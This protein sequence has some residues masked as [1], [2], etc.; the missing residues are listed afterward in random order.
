VKLFYDASHAFGCSHQGQMIGTFGDAEVFS[1]HA[2][3]FVNSAEGGA[4]MTN[5]TELAQRLRQ[6]RNFG[7]AGPD[8]V[9]Q[10][11]TNGKMTE[12]SAAMGLTSLEQMDQLI[13]TNI[14]NH[15]LYQ[16]SLANISGVELMMFSPNERANYQHIVIEIDQKL[17]GISRDHLAQIL[18]AENV[19]ARRY[20]HPGCHKMEP[21]RSNAECQNNQLPVTERIAESVLSLPTGTGVDA[22]KIRQIAD[23][24]RFVVE[25]G[26]AISHR[27]RSGPALDEADDAT[28][29]WRQSA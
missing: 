4:V 11:G 26:A 21:Y 27:V 12:F 18:R 24:I 2:T 10:L 3:K 15:R 23:I 1:F 20:F 25:H 28:S 22:A 19:L 8:Q 5:N 14:G 17:T 29:L 13:E 7:F 9:S 6:M 16:N